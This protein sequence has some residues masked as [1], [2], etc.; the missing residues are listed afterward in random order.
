M[1]PRRQIVAAPAPGAFIVEFALLG[2]V[3]FITLFGIIEVARV[4]YA[5]NT[6]HQATRRA[7]V[8]AAVTNFRDAPAMLAIRQN[9]IF[10]NSSGPLMFAAP[11]TDDTV[12]IDYVALVR[13]ASGNSTLAPISSGSLPS[14]TALNHL[15][16]MKNPNDASCMRFVRV[17]ICDKDDTGGCTPVKFAPLVSLVPLTV[18]L[19][20]ATT[21]VEAGSLGYQPGMAPCSY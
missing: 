10:R 1:K 16:C 6:V 13:D 19:P 3:F 14:C 7:A 12:R 21:I 20:I 4:M 17:R 11:V 15:I 5:Y 9:A 18:N 8:A 2:M